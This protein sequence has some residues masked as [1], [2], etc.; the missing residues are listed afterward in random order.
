[1]IYRLL[2]D[3]M[4]NSSHRSAASMVREGE[5]VLDVAC[6]T[7][8]LAYLIAR[9]TGSRVTGIDL[10]QIKLRSAERI[11][12]KGGIKDYRFVHMDATDLSAFAQNEFDVAVI[13]MA[14]HQFSYTVALDILTEMKRVATRIIIVDYG[15]PLKPGFL[16]W[17]T[18]VIEFIAGGDHYRNFR[19]YMGRGGVDPILKAAQLVLRK[20]IVRG[21]GTLVISSC[22]F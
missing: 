5:K 11:F 6:G 7:G 19:L 20:R 3:P 21:R 14:I 12:S 9:R 18:Y 1:M 2:I 17:L 10:D 8:A 15:F 4:L 16:K 22:D 13:S